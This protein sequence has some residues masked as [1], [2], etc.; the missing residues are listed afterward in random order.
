MKNTI[1]CFQVL[2]WA[3]ILLAGCSRTK[4]TT[5]IKLLNPKAET[6][7]PADFI[8]PTFTWEDQNLNAK[9]W[10]LSFNVQGKEILSLILAGQQKWKATPEEWETIKKQ[11]A[12]QSISLIINGLSDTIKQEAVSNA[13]IQFSFSVDSVEAP[14]FYRSVPL[15]FKHAREHLNE[16][17]WKLGYVDSEEKPYTVI[18]NLPVCGNCHSFSADGT[19][20]A[21]DVDARDEKGAYAIADFSET[22]EFS[23]DNIINWADF[24]NGEF[25]YG[26]LSALSPDGRYAISTLKDAEIFVDVDNFE[27]SQLFFPIKGILAWYDRETEKMAELPGANDT[28]WVNSNPTWSPDG[29]YIYFSRARARHFDESGIM[30]G[31]KAVDQAKYQLFLNNFLERK[32]LVKFDIYRVPFNEGKG[33][34]AEP[35]SGASGNDRS[36]YF[37]KISPDGKWMVYTQAESFMLLQKDSK[38]CIVST[39][40]G[41]ARVLNCNSDN[42]NSWHSWSP[43]GKWLVFASKANGPF[44]QLYLTHIDENG[45]DSPAVLLENFMFPNHVANIPEFVNTTNRRQY[46]IEPTFLESDEFALR[47]GEIKNKAGDY[48]GA[49]TDLTRAVKLVP[50]NADAWHKRGDVKM[51]LGMKKE[52]FADFDKAIAL[53][54]NKTDYW[55]SRGAA[56]SDLQKHTQAIEDLQQA[57]RIDPNSFLA[58]NN[59][60]F[61]YS[62]IGNFEAAMSNYNKALK[63]NPASYLT[64]VNIGIVEAR[65][66]NLDIALQYFEK[67]IDGDPDLAT[68]YAARA[69]AKEQMGD[70]E[71]AMNDY[72][73]AFRLDPGNSEPAFNV[74]MLKYKNKDINGALEVLNE[75][76]KNR[77]GLLQAYELS[78]RFYIELSQFTRARE[79]INVVLEKASENGAAVFLSGII[80]QRSGDP[81]KACDEFHR[82][83]SLGFNDAKD[84]IAKYCR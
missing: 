49:L 64:F 17:E 24:Q 54:P 29:K 50:G 52:A 62:R 10:Q 60:G 46:S 55:I 4:P 19:T 21:M 78:A 3:I 68:A 28:V 6:L 47:A 18:Q 59:L 16:I 83:Y 9:F 22:T 35:V 8:S 25:T 41:S 72:F 2:L 71:A 51:K 66:G 53:N 23:S 30:Y 44:T 79:E 76:K 32:D 33:G 82:A 73:K 63:L 61:A 43:N 34:I 57:V 11:S 5:D 1:L 80:Y 27:Y 31:S 40:G 36:N 20:I 37:P 38:L 81:E 13:G 15:P 12:N 65:K 48:K 42:M 26:L 77:G 14:I 84:A 7:F 75:I 39:D 74:S 56:N 45:N 67:A 70:V 69:K 58:Y